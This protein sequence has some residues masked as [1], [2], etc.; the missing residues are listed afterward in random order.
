MEDYGVKSDEI[1]AAK[2]NQPNQKKAAEAIFQK[3][4]YDRE[5][6]VRMFKWADYRMYA[7]RE[8][9]KFDFL[10]L[11][12]VRIDGDSAVGTLLGENGDMSEIGFRFEDERWR[13]ETD[14]IHDY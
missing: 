5:F 3:I 9:L 11:Q 6:L 12:D 13:V 8:G 2:T 1:Q 4:N 7:H 14:W 10:T